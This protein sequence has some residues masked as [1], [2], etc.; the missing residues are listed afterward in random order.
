[1]SESF[2]PGSP[3]SIRILTQFQPFRTAILAIPDD[4]QVPY[5]PVN[6]WIAQPWDTQGGLVSIAGDA[7]HPM[8]P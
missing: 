5:T 7:A 8:P 6:Y 1:M 4:T 3:V 2:L